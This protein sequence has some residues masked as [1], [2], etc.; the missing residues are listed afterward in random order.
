MMFQTLMLLMMLF[1]VI[2]FWLLNLKHPLIITIFVIIQVI[3][4]TLIM[5]LLSYSYWMSY[6]MFLIFIGGLLILFIYISS[7]TPNKIYYLNF[8]KLIFISLISIITFCFFK[9][10]PFIFNLE[11]TKFLNLIYLLNQENKNFI[12]NFYNNNEMYLTFMLINYLML[13]LIISTKI[14]NMTMGPMRIKF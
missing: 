8:N 13:T 1:M 7:L 6:I 14:S 3:N 10:Q 11:M 12:F 2:N 4:L 9:F 5:G